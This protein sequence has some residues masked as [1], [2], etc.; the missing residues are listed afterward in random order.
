MC[1]DGRWMRVL[2]AERRDGVQKEGRAI[3]REA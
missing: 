3:R 2:R 1:R